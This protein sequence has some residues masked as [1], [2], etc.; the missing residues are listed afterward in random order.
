MNGELLPM[1]ELRSI[2]DAFIERVVKDPMIGF[3]FNSIPI[4][5]LKER[6]LEFAAA[7]MGHPVSYTGRALK[8]AHAQHPIKGGHFE[9]RKKIL[10]ET[11]NEFDVPCTLKKAWLAHTDAL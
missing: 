8:Q 4:E 3:F 2:I 11:L 6:E 5:R 7:W 10:Q 1:E 9:R